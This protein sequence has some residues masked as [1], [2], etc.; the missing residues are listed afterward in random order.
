VRE[1][2]EGLYRTFSAAMDGLAPFEPSPRIAVGVSGG[3]DSMALALLAHGWVQQRGGALLALIVD[4]R[5]RQESGAEAAEAAARL[6]EHGIEARIL[7]LEG[8]EYGSAMAERARQAR[9]SVLVRACTVEG[10][11]HLLLGHHAADQA[12][13]VLIRA[14]GGSGPA[15]L[16]GIA[17]L[18]ELPGVR[19]LRPL[20]SVP[21]VS[22]RQYLRSAADVAWAEDPSN[23]DRSASRPRLRML[24]RDRD[25]TG[26]AT[27]AL[28]AAAR[29]S[30]RQRADAEQRV[31]DELAEHASLWPEGFALFSGPISAAAFASLVQ[32]V[33][34]AEYPPASDAAAR[35]ALSPKPATLS[36]VRLLRA[37]RLGSGWLLVR[38]A[39]AMAVPIAAHAGAVWDQRFR[40][41]ANLTAP[42]G[43]T[44]GPLGDD[45][46]RLRRFS[47]LPSAILRTLPAIRI[48]SELLAVPHLGYPDR[49]TCEGMPVVFAPL[50]PAAAAPY[51]FGDAC[52]ARTPYVGEAS[53]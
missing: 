13:T 27:R 4:H 5:L 1:A 22:L 25:G 41:G 21:P 34:G 7:P 11:L 47:H 52:G 51:R 46:P 30:G 14:L 31:A 6:A 9:F 44:V 48:A 35:I 43:S 10:V 45:T 12:E 2:A 32:M 23:S 26:P 38:E 15:G 17:S 28:V 53:C 3:A 39:A 24:R 49:K 37:G 40:L 18:T 50:R 8:L 16:A 20:L 33:S 19:I 36:G 42:E 29:A